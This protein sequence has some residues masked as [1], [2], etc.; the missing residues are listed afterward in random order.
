MTDINEVINTIND[1][2]AR[3]VFTQA[4]IAK[5]MGVADAT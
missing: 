3:D 4:T 5:E 2:I 1:L